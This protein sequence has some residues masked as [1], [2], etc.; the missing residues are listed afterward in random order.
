MQ[1][2]CASFKYGR[3]VFTVTSLLLLLM[4]NADARPFRG[5]AKWS[6]I[7]CRFQGSATPPNDANFYRNLLLQSGTGGVGDYWNDISYAN[8]N[9]EGSV[10][11]G[12]YTMSITEAQGRERD[13]W[14]KVNAC[15]DAASS[16]PSPY[17]P[18]SDHKIGI[19]TFP[20]VDMFGWNGGAF[21][22]Y[23]IDVGGVIHETGHG[24]GLSHSF[25]N[26]PNFRSADWAQIGEYDDP[27]DVM[28]WANAFRVPTP[29]GDGP[30]GLAGPHLDRMGWLPRSRIVTFGADGRNNVTLTVAALNHPET[31]GPLFVR[32]PFDPGDLQRHYTVEFRPK[33]RW[34][35][36]IPNHTVLI[37]E[38]QRRTDG[39]YYAHLIYEFSPTKRPAQTVS[40][41][42]ITIRVNSID[43][44]GNTANVTIT[45]QMVDRC[46][47]GFV[48]REAN[49]NDKVC[50]TSALRTQTREEN[51]LAASRRSPTGGPSGP[52]TCLQGFVWREAVMGDRVCVPPWSRTQA[53]KDNAEAANR[54]NSSRLAFGPNSCRPGLVWREADDWDWVCVSPETRT[55][56][57]SDNGFATS[58]RSPTGG[59]FGADTCRPGFV[60]RDA[61]PRDRVCVLPATRSQARDDNAQA[62]ARLAV[63]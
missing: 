49:A 20:D 36:G 35:A 12:W 26:D 9:L 39:N 53:Q 32:I 13:R 33:I 62:E 43:V 8:L 29:F 54:R 63:R 24:I 15:R 22:P 1:V 48:W 19:I 27:W 55:Q 2:T 34:D 56:T 41:N 5:S 17:T 30:V 52:D 31:P 44:A 59:P 6:F 58:R 3:L 38:V 25:S 51:R 4:V 40:A 23:N 45:S 11:A 14:G 60:W 10:V 42:G 18:P 7:L 37:H 21:L 16:S 61:F 28:S 47:T 46:L 57:R 50:V